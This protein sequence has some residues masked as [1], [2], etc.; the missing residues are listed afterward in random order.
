MSQYVVFRN[1]SATGGL[2]SAKKVARD[3]TAEIPKL[4][5]HYHDYVVIQAKTAANAKEKV[6]KSR[7]LSRSVRI[8]S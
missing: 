2:L 6:L 5:A 8:S 3:G 4:V 7:A 1:Q